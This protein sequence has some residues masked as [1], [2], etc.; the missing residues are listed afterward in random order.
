[1]AKKS[2]DEYCSFCGRPSSQAGMLLSGL[3]GYICKD[4]SHQA[5]QIFKEQSQGPQSQQ[6]TIQSADIPV[7][8]DIK[9]FLDQ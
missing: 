5:E 8:S 6:F 7:P 2:S 3:N 4:C 1:M 9:A